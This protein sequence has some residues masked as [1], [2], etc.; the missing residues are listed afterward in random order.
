MTPTLWGSINYLMMKEAW[1][2]Y[3]MMTGYIKI[4]TYHI[5]SSP[6][7][8]FVLVKSMSLPYSLCVPTISMACP[9]YIHAVSGH[10]SVNPPGLT[11]R[12]GFLRIPLDIHLKAQDILCLHLRWSP[13]STYHHQGHFHLKP[14]HLYFYFR[15]RTYHV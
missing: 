8:H 10:H 14:A 5:V 9:Y 15:N 13:L 11:L 3:P 7:L 4:A 12:R 1:D 6:I 2:V